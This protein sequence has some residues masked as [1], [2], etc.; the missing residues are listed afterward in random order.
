MG[1]R[2]R[3]T[4]GGVRRPTRSLDESRVGVV[5]DEGDGQLSEVEL[6]GSRDDVDVLVGAGGDVGLLTVCSCERR[7]GSSE[8][9][10]GTL[11]TAHARWDREG[12][13]SVEGQFDVLD[14]LAEA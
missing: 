6:E 10:R 2:Y 8:N 4:E 11:R 3:C 14:Q 12:L 9:G 7:K 5:S 1:R 13:T